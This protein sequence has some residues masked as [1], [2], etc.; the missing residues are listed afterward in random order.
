MTGFAVIDLETTGF[1]YNNT[2]RVCEIRVVLVAPDGRRED[3]WSTLV[4]PQR[5][6]GAQH[7]HRIDALACFDTARASRPSLP[8]WWAT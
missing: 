5:D 2:E 7:V 6:L 4:N 8:T 3:C 1:A